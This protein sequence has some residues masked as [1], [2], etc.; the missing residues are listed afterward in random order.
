MA[1]VKDNLL[2]LDKV[3]QDLNK[4][5]DENIDRID[6][7]SVV[8]NKFS[9]ESA[10]MPS[11]YVTVLNNTKKAVD[12]VTISSKKLEQQSIKESNARNALNKQREQSLAQL[13]GPSNALYTRIDV[14]ALIAPFDT[15]R[16]SSK[17]CVVTK[18]KTCFPSE[19]P[20]KTDKD[21]S[22]PP[23]LKVPVSFKT[24]FR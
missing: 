3:V 4:R 20:C 16:T 14:K 24:P 12:D 6:K 19:L 10:N 11:Q 9:K 23:P 5:L 22:E 18:L 7:L 13:A 21:K 1:E 2:Q 17:S 8:Y 15:K